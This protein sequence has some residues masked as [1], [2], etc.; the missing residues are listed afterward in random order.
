MAFVDKDKNKFR[1]RFRKEGKLQSLKDSY[2]HKTLYFP[3]R[4]TAETYL[5]NLNMKD[6]YRFTLTHLRDT[7]ENQF[8]DFKEQLPKFEKWHKQTAPAT[9]D[10]AIY[11]L[12][13]YVFPFF[14]G[15]KEEN[16]PL[17]WRLHFREFKEHLESA[18]TIKKNRNKK[19]GTTLLSPASQ[20][21]VLNALNLFLKFLWEEKHFQDVPPKCPLIDRKKLGRRTAEDL[22]SPDEFNR[23]LNGFDKLLASYRTEM[24]LQDTT[25]KRK[26][27][28]LDQMIKTL[29]VRDMLMVL[30]H[31]GMR[32]GEVLGLSI[33]DFVQ[34]ELDDRKLSKMLA[35]HNIK[36]LGYIRLK[37]QLASKEDGVVSRKPLKTKRSM[38][39]EDGRYIPIVD[40]ECFAVLKR[41][42]LAARRKSPN[43][44]LDYLTSGHVLYFD[45]ITKGVAYYKLKQVYEILQAGGQATKWKPWHCNRHSRTTELTKE[46]FNSEII[47][48]IIGHTS[49]QYERY[50]H[51][52]GEVLESEV[53]E[54]Y[55]LGI[56]DEA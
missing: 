54:K 20:N 53:D 46:T 14:L 27:V 23:Y 26:E 50:V 16:N 4:E 29:Q 10:R 55:I 12:Q 1:I 37:S 49:R 24:E 35:Q 45:S 3:T 30:Y 9:Y 25:D 34:K 36:S 44:S 31:T 43:Q 56:E 7:W 17:S 41:L 51:L 42:N 21:H 11:N 15:N 8:A 38:S 32:L 39:Y 5:K 40:D 22:I 33:G 28:L 18:K 47:K 52:A 13:H 19:S 6:D 2:T 48:L